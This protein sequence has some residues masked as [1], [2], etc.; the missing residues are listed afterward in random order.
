MN[1][2]MLLPEFDQ[3]FAATRRTL[4]RV[5]P[6]RF[7][8]KPHEKS[9][10]LQELAAHLAEIP[11][12]VPVT[13]EQDGLDLDED[14]YERFVPE[15]RDQLLSHFDEGV[16]AARKA[17]ED[18]SGDTLAET[19]TMKGGGQVMLSMPKAAVLRGFVFSHNIHHRAQLGVYLR[20][21]DIPVP[22][23]YGPSAD[24]QG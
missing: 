14:S 10:S 6:E 20:L 19:W 24:E 9:Y 5:A 13:L 23:I 8:W 15:T 17:L 1:G 2:A 12:W 3:E 21:L 16:K 4:E 18:V 7:D 11:H 22:S